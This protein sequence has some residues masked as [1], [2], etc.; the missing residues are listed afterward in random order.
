MAIIAMG[1]TDGKEKKGS[2]KP[3]EEVILARK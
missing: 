2:R 3:L 1:H